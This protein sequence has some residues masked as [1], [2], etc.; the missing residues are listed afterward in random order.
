MKISYNGTIVTIKHTD[1]AF[2]YVTVGTTQIVFVVDGENRRM[3]DI[4]KPH[5]DFTLAELK[6]LLDELDSIPK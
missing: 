3:R 5:G 1:D 2:H 4:G 6:T